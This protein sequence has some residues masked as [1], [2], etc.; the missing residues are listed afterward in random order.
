MCI[1]QSLAYFLP[2]KYMKAEIITL[3][4]E[5]LDKLSGTDADVQFVT[6]N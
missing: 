6:C 1:I 4:K 3:L 5:C 2:R